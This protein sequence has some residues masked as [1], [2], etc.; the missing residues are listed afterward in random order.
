[1]F[2]QLFGSKTRVK[3]LSLF[4]NNPERSYFVREIT[5]VI[6]EQINSVRRELSNLLSIGIISSDSSNNKLYYQVN[7]KYEYYQELHKIFSSI[8]VKHKV[9]D[10][11]KD[12]DQ[13]A[14][15]LRSTGAIQL[16]FLTGSFVRE[17][18]VTIDLLIVGDVNRTRVAKVVA[19]LERE[20]GRE[21]N[22][23]VFSVDD[24]EYRV[25]L[26]DRFLATVMDAKRIMLID[27]KAEA[28]LKHK[29]DTTPVLATPPTVYRAAEVSE[30]VFDRSVP[31]SVDFNDD[32]LEG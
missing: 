1:M 19:E 16:A 13:L 18:Y 12:D 4:L 20:K 25:N 5:R 23:A 21:I 24:Y 6:D 29:S 32:Y 3:L 8:P 31:M 11:I 14:T 2:E 28:R 26:N 9:S 17:P 15:K 30:P 22:Y 27:V 10:E 7:E